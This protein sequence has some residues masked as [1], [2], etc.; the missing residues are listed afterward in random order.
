MKIN[1]SAKEHAKKKSAKVE[2]TT[3][4]SMSARSVAA[5]SHSV[6][7]GRSSSAKSIE[8][9]IREDGFNRAIQYASAVAR[10][11]GL[12]NISPE[13]LTAGAFLAVRD[14]LLQ[15]RP[16][17]SAHLAANKPSVEAL[18]EARG[19]I[20]KVSDAT[21]N[22]EPPLPLGPEVENALKKGGKDC[23]PLIVALNVGIQTAEKFRM[24]RRI[25]Y[26]EAGH[27]IVSNILRPKLGIT[28]I[29]IIEKHNADGCT[30]YDKSSPYFKSA[31]SREDFLDEMCVC[32]AGRVAEQKKYGHDEID[33]GAASDLAGAT[34]QAWIAITRFGLDFEFGPINL[35]V[36]AKV[37]TK[38][39]G[40]L[41]DEAQRR[42]Q[43]ILK[44]SLQRTETLIAEN[45][46]KVEAVAQ[47]LF[48]RKTLMEDDFLLII[49]E[50]QNRTL[51]YN[52]TIAESSCTSMT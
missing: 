41:F 3:S 33:A 9:I 49:A 6:V 1:G 13:L 46:L 31:T 32:L 12:T 18:I 52:E 10:M 7:K 45:W 48:E 15:K 35:E 42:L 28:G 19:W 16:S 20:V 34:E 17:I 5:K 44:E 36:L 22:N 51:E 11:K 29:T 43:K 4:P 30:S 38:S 23:D 8:L 50:A 37:S 39:S 21:L 25:A 40:W 24:Q 47:E 2:V 26:H 14:G 27:A